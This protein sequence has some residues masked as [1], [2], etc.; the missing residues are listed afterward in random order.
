MMELFQRLL[1]KVQ[2]GYKET[3]KRLGGFLPGGGTGNPLSNVVRQI[4]P[5]E[6]A[7]FY[8]ANMLNEVNK[9]VSKTLLKNISSAPEQLTMQQLPAL[10]DAA[11]TRMKAAGFPGTWSPSISGREVGEIKN[12]RPGTKIVLSGEGFGALMGSPAFMNTNPLLGVDEPTVYATK[13][14]PGWVIAHELG[15]AVDAIK[16]PYDYSIP[17]GFDFD[18]P[19]SYETLRQSRNDAYS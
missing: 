19:N 9:K 15:H 7:A 14:T 2:Q 16:R 10:M 6:V 11:S 18:N 3:D 8:G 1:N 17:K 5:T 12:G 4:N 13:K